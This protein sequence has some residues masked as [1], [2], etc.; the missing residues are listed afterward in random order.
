MKVIEQKYN[1]I[2]MWMDENPELIKTIIKDRDNYSLFDTR[3]A[4]NWCEDV[5]KHKDLMFGNKLIIFEEIKIKV[6]KYFDLTSD[7]DFLQMVAG[8]WE[9][10]DWYWN[11][12]DDLLCANSYEIFNYLYYT[13]KLDKE[14]VIKQRWNSTM[15]SD[16]IDALFPP[17]FKA[18]TKTKSKKVLKE[19]QEKEKMS[20]ANFLVKYNKEQKHPNLEF[21]GNSLIDNKPIYKV[22]I[23]YGCE[24][25]LSLNDHLKNE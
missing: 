10:R 21:V 7:A 18:P 9:E 24:V 1:E 16:E 12:G 25:I 17:K 22:K 20:Y 8:N 2:K 15:F 23:P 4:I 3:N 13:L 6:S 19:K 11:Y 5:E 14:T